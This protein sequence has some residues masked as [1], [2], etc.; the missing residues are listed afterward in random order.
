[1]KRAIEEFTP[2][3]QV[4]ICFRN[5]ET[6]TDVA[7]IDNR[8]ETTEEEQ[9]SPILDQRLPI[10][11]LI[12]FGKTTW[13]LYEIRARLLFLFVSVDGASYK[14][15]NEHPPSQTVQPKEYVSA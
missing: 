7:G 9:P 15:Q 10:L 2:A 12:V 5:P 8:Y 14:A 4:K 6:V 11:V 1:M 3:A 13:A